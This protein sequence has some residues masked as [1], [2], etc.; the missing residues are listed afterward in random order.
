MFLLAMLPS[1]VRLVTA[2]ALAM[3]AAIAVMLG[4]RYVGLQA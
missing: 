3:L 1:R 4:L 2:F